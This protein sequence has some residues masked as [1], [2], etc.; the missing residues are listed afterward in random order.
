MSMALIE[1]E[2]EVDADEL[3]EVAELLGTTSAADTINAALRWILDDHRRG[4]A[5]ERLKERGRRGDFDYMLDSVG[6]N[7]AWHGKGS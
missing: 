2:I 3:A 4:E 5:L 1:E 7:G 6:E